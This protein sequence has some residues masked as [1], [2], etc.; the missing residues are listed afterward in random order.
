MAMKIKAEHYEYMKRAIEAATFDKPVVELEGRYRARGLTPKR[1]RWDCS[2]AARL[3]TWMCDNLYSYL[4]DTHI[5][6]ALRAI[7][8]DLNCDWAA[9]A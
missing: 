3:T 9:T 2:H 7:M 8:R 6:T 1:F 5:D 4:N